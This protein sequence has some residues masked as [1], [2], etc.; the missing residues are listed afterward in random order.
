MTHKNTNPKISPGILK[1]PV[2]CLAL[3][4]GTG[5]AAKAPGTFGTLVGIPLFIIMQSLPLATYCLITTS[6][7]LI[8]IWICDRTARE[9]GVHDHPGIVWDEVVGYLVTMIMA[10]VGWLWIIL[11]FI[12]FRI[13]DIWKPWPIRV[14]DQGVSGGFGIMLDDLIAGIFAL[15]SLHFLSFVLKTSLLGVAIT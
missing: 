5:L 2:H 1:D 12:L 3:G 7:F 8:G 11:G 13:F 14:I 6:L 4:F 10:P 15:V 9:L